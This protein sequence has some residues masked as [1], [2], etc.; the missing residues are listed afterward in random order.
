MALA[1]LVPFFVQAAL[2]APGQLSQQPSGPGRFP[3]GQM[4]KKSGAA[5]QINPAKPAKPVKPGQAE[6]YVHALLNYSVPLPPGT[7]TAESGPRKD[8]T[9]QSRKGY[10]IKIQSAKT[11]PLTKLE[12]MTR[13]LEGAYLGPGKPW[14]RRLDRNPAT[15][16]GMPALDVTYE[17]AR[18]RS[19]V[20]IVRGRVNDY[21]FMFFA[22]IK[23]FPALVGE[24][25]WVVENFQP[26]RG[27]TPP[28]GAAPGSSGAAMTS[29]SG[30]QRKHYSDPAAG[31]TIDYPA[32]WEVSTPS[33]FTVLITGSAGTAAFDA[34]VSIQNVKPPPGPPL[35]PGEAGGGGQRVIRTV[36]DN[37]KTQFKA[38]AKGLSYYGEKPASY[39]KNNQR[40]DG[41]EFQVT[42]DQNGGRLRQWTLIIPRPSGTIAHIW[43]FTAPERSFDSFRP[44]VEAMLRSWT[45][46][47]R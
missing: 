34:S 36:L 15:V 22:P 29:V 5:A 46:V 17:G 24:F 33:P 47:G 14:N 28:P 26:P 16:A 8:V 43:S 41:V 11:K 9:V 40:L 3:Q 6:I 39:V 45:I 18:S 13:R 32:E 31:F 7:R 37:L 35:A 12:D 30:D 44:I 42:Y 38:Q 25:N 1:L 21:V 4:P 2:A 20:V 23:Q 10:M 19:R 27:E